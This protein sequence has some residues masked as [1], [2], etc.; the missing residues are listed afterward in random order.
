MDKM[1]HLFHC[2]FFPFRA[3]KK[4]EIRVGGGFL[5]LGN[6]GGRGVLG[7]R[8]IQSEGGVKNACHLSGGGVCIF[9]GLTQ[10]NLQNI[11]I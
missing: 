2:L 8:E 10:F 1:L 3:S 5:K 7:V 4:M 9:S 11:E 6:P